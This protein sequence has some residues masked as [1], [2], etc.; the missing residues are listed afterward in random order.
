MTEDYNDLVKS[1][2]ADVRNI[3]KDGYA[4]AIVGAIFMQHF[5]QKTP[6]AHLDIAGPAFLAEEKDYNPKGGS[7]ATVRLLIDALQ[8]WETID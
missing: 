1:D 5:V 2:V 3:G 6:W 4:G 8:K 7:G